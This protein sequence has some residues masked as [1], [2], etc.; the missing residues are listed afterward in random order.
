ME[1]IKTIK[2]KNPYRLAWFITYNKC[3]RATV[4]LTYKNSE[5]PLFAYAFGNS[6]QRKSATESGQMS[7][8]DNHELT[9]T[10]SISKANQ[11]DCIAKKDNIRAETSREPF[12]ECHRFFFETSGN[13][14]YQDYSGLTV[15]LLNFTPPM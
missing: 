9:L 12:A 10:V 6:M 14:D 13:P 3:N 7:D 1:I 5:F 2:F 15:T 8:L 4:T 11:I